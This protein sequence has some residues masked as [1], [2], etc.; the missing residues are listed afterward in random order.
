M[1]ISNVADKWNLR[2]LLR[3][4]VAWAVSALLLL[5]IAS[6]I[7]SKS[8]IGAG[9]LG[10]VSSGISFL[11]AVFAG[12][13]AG[14]AIKGSGL[15]TG[16]LTAALLSVVLLTV[17]FLIEGPALE[18]S[19]VLSIVTF[20]FSGCLVGSVFFGSRKGRGKK[21]GFSPKVRH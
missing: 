1:S 14:R 8:S 10:Y 9:E 2:F 17:G 13:F 20:S 6:L 16:L 21:T 11:A 5:L 15:Y 19:G 7:V 12:I 18:S 3:A 4:L